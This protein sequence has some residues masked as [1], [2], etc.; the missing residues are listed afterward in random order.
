MSARLAAL[1]G[2]RTRDEWDAAFDGQGAC[3]TPVLTLTEAA[4][5]PHNVARGTFGIVGGTVGDSGTASIAPAAAPRYLG[6]PA[7]APQPAPI[8]GAH[9]DEVLAELG[10]RPA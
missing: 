2:T 1:F 8:V 9:T 6:T 7:A 3:V 10:G 5:H 4:D